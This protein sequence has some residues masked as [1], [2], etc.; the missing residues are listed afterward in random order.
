MMVVFFNINEYGPNKRA[1]SIHNGSGADGSY[2]SN[3]KYDCGYMCQ[4]TPSRLP[5]KQ[6]K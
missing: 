5:Q 1:L 6:I 3:M 2:T 4:M